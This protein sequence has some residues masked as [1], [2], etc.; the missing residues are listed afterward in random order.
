MKTPPFTDF[1][2]MDW[3]EI[4]PL[5]QEL[6]KDQL[7]E[8]TLITWMT[9]WSDL[10]K[11]VDERYARLSL[12]TELDTTDEEAEKAYHAFLENVYPK[13]QAADQKLKEKLLSSGLEPEGMEIILR[14]MRTEAALFREEN[15]P[16]MT[17]ESKLGTQYSKILGAQMIEWKGEELTLTQGKSAILTTDREVRKQLWGLTSDRQLADRGAINDLWVMFMGIRAQLAD[18][19]GY[20]DYRSGPFPKPLPGI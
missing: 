17:N 8:K 9:G 13:A 3:E 16:L 7:D 5:Y 12:A 10:R 2:E 15:L 18:N 14:K 20:G 1:L 19:A 4:Q 6:E 11:L